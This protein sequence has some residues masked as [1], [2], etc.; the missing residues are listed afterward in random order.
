V[1]VTTSTDAQTVLGLGVTAEFFRTLGQAPLLGRTLSE[2]DVAGP[3]AVVLSY[4]FWQRHFGNRDAI[5]TALNMS[6]VPY[7]IVGV[8]PRDFEVRVLDM[9]FDFWIPLRGNEPG[10]EPGGL[11]PVAVIARLRDGVTFEAAQLEVAA[12]TRDIES[13]YQPNFNTFIAQITSLQAD[14]TRTVR[15]TLLTVAAAV[16][17]LLLISATNVGTLLLGRGIGRMRETAIRA[18]IGCGRTRLIRQFLTESL[19]MSLAGSIGGLALASVAVRAFDVWNPLGM[20]PANAIEVDARA[21]IAAAIAMGVTTIVAGVVPAVRVSKA[22]PQ[23]VH[24]SSGG[25]STAAAPAQRTQLTMLVAQMTVCVMLL[26]ATALLTQTFVRLQ[27]EPLGFKA[28]D[29]FV[30]N[31]VLPSDAFDTSARRNAYCDAVANVLLRLPHVK[32]VAAGTSRPLNSG[33]PAT[34]R[35][36]VEDSAKAPRISAQA[37]TSEFFETLGISLVAGRLFDERDNAA[38]H[39]S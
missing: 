23:D 6:G 14:N 38:A 16:A 31:V 26:V 20:L 10:Y 22:D 27:H 5:G 24:R 30:A 13:H 3:R 2:T 17:C 11:G 8:M 37:V 15:S 35:T 21:V 19:L 36:S 1:T 32:A 34:V 39:K 25:H 28:N 4:G 12:F 7:E 18:A 33:A 9:R 29:L